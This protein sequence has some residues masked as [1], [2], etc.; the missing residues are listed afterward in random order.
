MRWAQRQ[1]QVFAGEAPKRV[2]VIAFDS[3]E[4]AKKYRQSA[5]FQKLQP[6]RE[7]VLRYI[8]NFAVEGVPEGAAAAVG[9]SMAPG[10]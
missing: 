8:E 9:S 3:M 2:V 4:D 1:T 6:M 5:E 10:K 7:K